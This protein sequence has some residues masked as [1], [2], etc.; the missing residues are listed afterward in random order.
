MTTSPSSKHSLSI[1]LLFSLALSGLTGAAERSKSFDDAMRNAGEDGVVAFCY[2]PDWNAR[3]VR[4]LESFWEN[5]E[6]DK[7]AGE[8][9]LVAVPFYQD[10]SSEDAVK[11]AHIKGEM[12]A[13]PFGV[14]PTVLMYDKTGRLYATLVGSDYLGGEDGKLGM[15]NI[16]LKLEALRKQHEL[17]EK[18]DDANGEEEAKLLTEASELGIA[19][20]ANAASQIIAASAGDDSMYSKRLKYSA[21]AFLYKQ[22]ETGDGFLKADFIED[23]DKIKKA[24]LEIVEDPTYKPMD[25][26]AANNLY[27]GALRRDGT[28]SAGFM[29]SAIKTSLKISKTTYYAKVMD[30]ISATW[31]KLKTKKSSD[32]R[33]KLRDAKKAKKAN[34]RKQKSTETGVVIS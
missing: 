8:A 28:K 20:P 24:C 2:G 21:L 12:A 16:K 29:R 14:C 18:A 30:Q 31:T 9:I 19:P 6:M 4:M 17:V 26:Q 15:E 25:R 10:P 1:C 5:P 33:R 34:E 7:A 27:L 32:Q 22:M 3:S 11:D 13:P 23:F